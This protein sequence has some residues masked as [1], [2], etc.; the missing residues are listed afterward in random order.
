M[1]DRS[2]RVRPTISDDLSDESPDSSQDH[3]VYESEE[4]EGDDYDTR[5]ADAMRRS[6]RQE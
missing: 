3:D 1:A 2:R 4:G 5:R 6:A